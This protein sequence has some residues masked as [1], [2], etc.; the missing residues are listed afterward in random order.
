MD[1]MICTR[2]REL[3]PEEDQLN[4]D[5]TLY[6][7]REVRVSVSSW[8]KRICAPLEEADEDILGED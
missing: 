1:K 3:I 4:L 7:I 2:C 5:G 8:A 6:H